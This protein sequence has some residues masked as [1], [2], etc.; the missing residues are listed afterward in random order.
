MM[1]LFEPNNEQNHL[2]EVHDN[3]E[4]KE[5]K[6][7]KGSNNYNALNISILKQNYEKMQKEN[8]NL[9]NINEKLKKAINNMVIHSKKKSNFDKVKEEI[10]N[11][12]EVEGKNRK[13]SYVDL[14]LDIPKM[15]KENEENI[16]K[17]SKL[18]QNIRSFTIKNENLKKANK[19]IESKVHQYEEEIKIMKEDKL[20]QNQIIQINE[21]KRKEN[22][23][24]VI[25][26]NNLTK[27]NDFIK[28]KNVNLTK[29]IEKL[30]LENEELK[31][32]NE[33]IKNITYDDQVKKLLLEIDEKNTKIKEQEV[34]I[35]NLQ[36]ENE[37]IKHLNIDKINQLKT[38]DENI[39]KYKINLSQIQ[40]SN[41]E[42]QN[43]ITLLQKEKDEI[44]LSLQ[45]IKKENEQ[46]IYDNQE[47]RKEN[48]TYESEFKNLNERLIIIQNEKN[49]NENYFLDQIS[50]LQKEKNYYENSYIELQNMKTVS[51]N[52]K[53]ENPEINNNDKYVMALKEI[54]NI[55]KDNKK[56]L[57]Y[58]EQLNNDIENVIKENHFYYSLLKRISSFH[59]ED[60]QIKEK[61]N[62]LLN[63]YSSILKLNKEKKQIKNQLA[64]YTLFIE[65]MNKSN[66]MI[67]SKVSYNFR[68]FEE[69]SIMQNELINIENQLANLTEKFIELDNTFNCK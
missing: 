68:N 40:N 12:L 13:I 18:E 26:I 17:I 44:N 39:E 37:T 25:E 32:E 4:E 51:L 15:K 54:M 19:E 36:R 8:K 14:I 43:K 10:E 41:L 58:N 1:E 57:Q 65:D 35:Q 21:E 67:N 69:I 49:K 63:V 7:I 53:I 66:Q 62:E 30:S 38:Q 5:K 24:M 50:I 60:I 61:A 31:N 6:I 45:N 9:K 23:E 3:D 27:Q 28:S 46:I 22:E 29:N 33:R 48:S 11:E 2:I 56:L 55:K 42:L 59:I 52:E 34:V 47:L 64:S 20:K 16:N